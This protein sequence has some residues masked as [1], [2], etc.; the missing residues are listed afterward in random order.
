MSEKTGIHK[1]QISRYERGLTE[2][3]P[4]TMDK[5]AEYG[6]L[7]FNL[8]VAE[9]KDFYEAQTMQYKKAFEKFKKIFG[10]ENKKG[11]EVLEASMDV[12]IEMIRASK[13]KDENKGGE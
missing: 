10:S 2:P 8:Y 4:K 3:R 5:I 6:G 9:K 7:P 12:I 11:I 13:G 1:Q